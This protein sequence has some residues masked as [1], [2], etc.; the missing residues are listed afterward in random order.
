MDGFGD[1]FVPGPVEGAPEVD[2]AAEFLA[3]EQD[4]LAGLDDDIVPPVAPQS[5]ATTEAA[6]ECGPPKYFLSLPV[7]V[8]KNDHFACI[9]Q[10]WK[11]NHGCCKD[12]HISSPQTMTGKM[13]LQK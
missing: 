2:P 13:A 8:G 4:Q 5:Q 12:M 9:L 1:S 3:R 7:W 6:G 10:H 11:E